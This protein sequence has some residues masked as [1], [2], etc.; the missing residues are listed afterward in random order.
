MYTKKGESNPKFGDFTEAIKIHVRAI[1]DSETHY[2]S[3]SIEK[4]LFERARIRETRAGDTA[5]AA[6]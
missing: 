5:G 1:F 4:G 3:W 6:E 2:S